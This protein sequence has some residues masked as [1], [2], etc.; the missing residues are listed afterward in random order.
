MHRPRL[1]R[2]TDGYDDAYET[3]LRLRESTGAYFINSDDPLRIEDRKR[4]H[5]KFSSRV[6]GQL[7]TLS[8][9]R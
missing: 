3:T 5:S 7:A 8:S 1:L 4:S 9:S 6:L 2:L